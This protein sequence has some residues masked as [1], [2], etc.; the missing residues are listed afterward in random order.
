MVLTGPVS[1]DPAA[2]KASDVNLSSV[3]FEFDSSQISEIEEA[4]KCVLNKKI[5]T[6]THVDFPLP[7]LG[8]ILAQHVHSK[9]EG[10]VGFALL[11][12]LPVKKWGE[13]KS[14]LAVR[15]LLF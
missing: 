7:T 3:V 5:E 2:W 8:P 9:L 10:D 11:R 15:N 6:V 12:G 4:L 13:P 1:G 14:R